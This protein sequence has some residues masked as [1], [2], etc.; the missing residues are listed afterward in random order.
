MPPAT[1]AGGAGGVPQG[2]GAAEGRVVLALAAALL[3]SPWGQSRTGGVFG[4][5]LIGGSSIRL[6]GRVGDVCPG[7]ARR[8]ARKICLESRE[9]LGSR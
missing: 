3:L 6:R 4:A 9:S 8:S 5:L 7:V 1:A 2:G